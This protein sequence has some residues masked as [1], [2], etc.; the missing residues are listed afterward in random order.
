[1][2]GQSLQHVCGWHQVEQRFPAGAERLFKGIPHSREMVLQKLHEIQQNKS[3]DLHLGQNK[4][5]QTSTL[6]TSWPEKSFAEEDLR[7]L[8][9][10]LSLDQHHALVTMRP[11]C[12]QSC[13]CKSLVRN[14]MYAVIL[15]YLALLTPHLDTVS[16]CGP[17]SVEE[18]LTNWSE[19]SRGHR[20][21]W[22]AGAYD[23]WERDRTNKFC[24]A[25]RR[26]DPGGK[27]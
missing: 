6:G 23:S 20:G 9:D 5:V 22:G 3:K 21:G 7:V 17:P 16:S 25:W 10:N 1:M 26:C 15:P 11:S 8:V 4:L 18:I 24:S 19:S 13:I 2:M 14:L 27:S 12:V